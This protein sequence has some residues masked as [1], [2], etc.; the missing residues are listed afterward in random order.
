M[1]KNLSNILLQTS[2]YLGLAQAAACPR[3]SSSDS[4]SSYEMN[5]EIAGWDVTCD[6]PNPDNHG[7][8]RMDAV[9]R[10]WEGAMEMAA[11]SW[12]RWEITK[13]KLETIEK[14]GANPDYVDQLD[15]DI[16]D[17]GYVFR[18]LL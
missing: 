17:P 5:V 14:S 13:P 1:M 6:L 12:D 7:E 10:A 15:V 2:L 8:T 4:T 16:D 18:L 11:D 3:G 9:K